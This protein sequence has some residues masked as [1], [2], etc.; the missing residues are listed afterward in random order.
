MRRV[1]LVLVVLLVI[2]RAAVAQDP[3]PAILSMRER[4]E[5]RDAWLER[6]L[7]TV[8]PMLMRREGIDL[9]VLVAREYNEDPVLKTMLPATWL[10]A[11]RRTILLFHDRGSDADGNDLGVER[12][13]IARYAVGHA[14][15]AAW[16]PDTQPDQWARVAELIAER[17]SQRI[18]LNRSTTFALA[19]GLTD[20]EFDGL[21]AALSEA[22][23]ARI[24]SGEALSIGW[25]ETRIPEEMAVYPQIVKIAQ[26]IIAEGFSEQVITPG[27][28]TVEDVEWWYRDRIRDLNL[29]TWFHPSVS[30]QRATSGPRSGDFSDWGSGNATI[31][32][33][34]LLHVDLGITYLG[35]NTDTQEHAYVLRP[36]EADAPGDLKAALAVGNRLQDILTDEFAAGRT[37]NEILAAALAQADR[38]GIDATIYTHPLGY[39]GHG[40]G[41]SIGMWDKQGGVPGKGDYPLYANTA[42]SIELNAAVPIPAWDDQPVRIML[43]QDAF[44]DGEAVWY[45][46]GRQTELHLVPRASHTGPLRP[47]PEAAE[48]GAR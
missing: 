30:V 35:L 4:A 19:D 41:P 42:H 22:D 9:W 32:P 12:L 40:A 3:I 44:F 36:G 8:V 24:V 11:R 28:T 18:A 20:T 6:R 23:R 21:N 17:D 26:A 15:P 34:D 38:E 37:G 29:V 48:M 14:F 47:V 16:D 31:Q 27:V 1:M 5:V 25:L 45:I 7:D 2:P 39:H 46:D 33:G 10:N 13:A 43:E